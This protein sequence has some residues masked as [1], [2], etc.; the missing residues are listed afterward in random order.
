MLPPKCIVAWDCI[1]L[2]QHKCIC[3]CS[4]AIISAQGRLEGH[5]SRMPTNIAMHIIT[6]TMFTLIALSLTD[7]EW[8]VAIWHVPR[9]A[10]DH[11]QVSQI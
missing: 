9:C 6:G 5:M 3:G 10:H 1:T 4:N 7:V 11:S 2:F 8:K